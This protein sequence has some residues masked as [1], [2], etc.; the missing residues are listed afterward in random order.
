MKIRDFVIYTILIVVTFS[1]GLVL[2]GEGVLQQKF[3]VDTPPT[4]SKV[5]KL[6]STINGSADNF[7]DSV[8]SPTEQGQIDQNFD[9][10][11]NS[12]WT[13]T[14]RSIDSLWESISIIDG[15]K[16]AV[17][18]ILYYL[19]VNPIISATIIILIVFSIGFALITWWKGKVP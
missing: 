7:G 8:L 1:L 2:V 9:L 6:Q 14:K 19:K 12:F 18:E 5:S 15:S 11:D 3:G 4:F 10:N 16:S 13:Y 17:T